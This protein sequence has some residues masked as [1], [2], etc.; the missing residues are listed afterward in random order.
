MKTCSYCGR[1][2]PD[3]TQ[4][5][6]IDQ[7]PLVA[8]TEPVKPSAE[9]PA[10]K[11]YCPQCGAADDFTRLIDPRG[12]FSLPVFLFSG[13]TTILFHNAGK[14]RRARCNQCEA[15]FTIARPLN[16][17]ARVIFWLLIAAYT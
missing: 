11:V 12:S 1:Q 10:E 6:A 3:D 2:Y 17:I 15:R 4:V 13:I 9:I 8:V 14:T 7:Q 16:K 5:C